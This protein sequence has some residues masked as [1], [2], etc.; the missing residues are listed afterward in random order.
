MAGD[1]GTGQKMLTI[2]FFLSNIIKHM[3]SS[4]KKYYQLRN[5]YILLRD[6]PGPSGTIRDWLRFLA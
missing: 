6:R 2:H 4:K 1:N 3:L 5:L